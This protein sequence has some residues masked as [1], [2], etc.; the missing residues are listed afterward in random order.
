MCMEKKCHWPWKCMDFDNEMCDVVN[1]K[2]IFKGIGAENLILSVNE[3][4]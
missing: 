3:L 2:S 1:G 4:Q